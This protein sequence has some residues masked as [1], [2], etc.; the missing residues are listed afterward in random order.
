[1]HSQFLAS[2]GRPVSWPTRKRKSSQELDDDRIR[3]I[4]EAQK[5]QLFAEAKSEILKY[6]NKSSRTEDY[7]R[8]LK[9]QIEFQEL[10]LRRV[11]EECAESRREQDLLHQ[12]VADRERA[13]RETHV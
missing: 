11:L 5:E 8:G 2:T 9:C 10:D 12:E 7:T 4:L 1:M 3:T 6:G 13:L